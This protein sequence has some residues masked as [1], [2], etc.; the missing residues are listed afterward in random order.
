MALQEP[1]MVKTVEGSADLTL[2][3]ETGESILVKDIMVANPSSN[4]AEISVERATVGYWRVGG[5][6]GNH[7]IFPE[8]DDQVQTLLRWLYEND[9]HAGY[10]VTEGQTLSI[11]GVA[12]AGAVQTVIYELYEAGDITDTDV[13]GSDAD[14]YQFMQYSRVSGGAGDGDNLL[15]T[16]QSPT[17]FP[18][19]P[20]GD[21]VGGNR[22]LEIIGVA[23]SDRGYQDSATPENR[24]TEYLKGVQERTTFFDK[25]RV[26]QPNIALHPDDGTLHL[27][28]GQSEFGNHSDADLRPVWL[29]PTELI[30]EAGD[31]LDVYHSVSIDSG[32][33]FAEGDL[34]TCFIMEK[35]PAGA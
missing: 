9:I 28:E 3:A 7:L 23:L 5:A 25:E 32:A 18:D 26:G 21:Q 17:Q 1:Y 35:R 34:E 10:P 14:V 22:E 16:Q 6:L 4:Y 31:E 24:Y 27:G 30:F 11:E 29:S 33:D 2:E 8:A 15:D 12:Q 13:N 19:F 20:L